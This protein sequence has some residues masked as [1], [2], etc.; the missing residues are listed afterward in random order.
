MNEDKELVHVI[1]N[2]QNKDL[3]DLK[4]VNDV[5]SEFNKDLELMKMRQE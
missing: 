2:K 4:G 3:E 5:L 1:Q